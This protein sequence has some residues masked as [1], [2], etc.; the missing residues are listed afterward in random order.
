MEKGVVF[1]FFVLFGWVRRGEK[2]EG[3]MGSFNFMC[4]FMYFM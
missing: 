3:K 4:C 1:C 2:G